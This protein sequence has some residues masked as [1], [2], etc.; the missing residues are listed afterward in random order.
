[1]RRPDDVPLSAGSYAGYRNGVVYRGVRE[2][3][4]APPR[5]RPHSWAVTVSKGV[6]GIYN[7][8]EY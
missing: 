1:M 6:L 3:E 7:F 2:K 8:F 4:V 5:R